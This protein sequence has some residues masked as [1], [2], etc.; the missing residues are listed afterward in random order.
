[1]LDVIIEK[2]K[3]DVEKKS[4]Q[5][6]YKYE[7]GDINLEI[8]ISTIHKVKGE[9][10][11]ATLIVETFKNGYDLFHLLKLLQGKKFAGA[12]KDKK[13]LL[14]VAMSRA[15]HFLCLAIHREQKNGK[16]ITSADITALESSGF[17]VISWLSLNHSTQPAS[18]VQKLNK[19][20]LVIIESFEW[21]NK[22]KII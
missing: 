9:T 3:I 11:T 12:N 2:Y 19:L 20:K 4:K 16:L 15:T 7:D 21:Y 5:N 8:E 10:H 6:I 1:M 22:Y 17:R 14:Y 13:K 18:N